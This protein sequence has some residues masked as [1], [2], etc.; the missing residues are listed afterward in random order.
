MGSKH[1]TNKSVFNISPNI[2]VSVDENDMGDMYVYDQDRGYILNGMTAS[3]LVDFFDYND[4]G[5]VK[6]EILD[7]LIN[8][9]ITEGTH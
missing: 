6:E 2:V 5:R 3:D 4:N 1:N 8:M 9:T 7:V